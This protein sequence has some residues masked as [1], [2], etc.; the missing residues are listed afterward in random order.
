MKKTSDRQNIFNIDL[1]AFITRS[2][3]MAVLMA[4][5]IVGMPVLCAQSNKL[6]I[7]QQNATYEE[8]F[9]DIEAKTGFKFVYNTSEID[10]NTRATVDAANRSLSEVLHTIFNNKNIG[11]RIS[12]KHIVLY[13]VTIKKITGMVTDQV[14]DPIIGAS[15]IV[16]GTSRGISTDFDGK[17]SLD[18]A[19]G[20]TV[21]VSF[22]GYVTQNI[23]VT[24]KDN[25]N[26]T[27]FS[28]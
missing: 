27:L 23:P 12:N 28:R 1:C 13:K 8:I 10:K 16:R 17:F 2:R 6:S 7:N 26:I 15:V 21:Q 25:Y 19:E 22:V 9:K 14:G 4:F 3:I 18:A 11:Y 20:D 24:R 5:L